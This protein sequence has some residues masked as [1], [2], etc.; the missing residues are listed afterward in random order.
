VKTS[1]F[2][3]EIPLKQRKGGGKEKWGGLGKR[4]GNPNTKWGIT[5]LEDLFL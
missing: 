3:L 4:E 2:F 5:E 1:K